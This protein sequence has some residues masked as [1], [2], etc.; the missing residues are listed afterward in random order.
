MHFGLPSAVAA[1][2]LASNSVHYLSEPHIIH[3]ATVITQSILN[4]SPMNSR[5]SKRNYR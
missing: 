4:G 1:I 2:V 5:F 3:G